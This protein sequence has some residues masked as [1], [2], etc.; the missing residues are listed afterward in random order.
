MKSDPLVASDEAAIPP[1][2]VRRR[3][4]AELLSVSERTL[5]AW[6]KA[7]KVP[8]VRV[9]HVTLYPVNLLRTWLALEAAKTNGGPAS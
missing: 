6:T 9:G 8:S 1:L 3:Q 5:W 2:A 7:G 4:A